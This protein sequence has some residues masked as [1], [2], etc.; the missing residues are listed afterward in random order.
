MVVAVGLYEEEGYL[1]LLKHLPSDARGSA[2][3]YNTPQC[4]PSSA[5]SSCSSVKVSLS[6]R[7]VV[8]K[9]F[10]PIKKRDLRLREACDVE[11]GG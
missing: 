3:I 1:H 2:N 9:L 11:S 8:R 5:I 10:Q 6:A 4:S 7:P